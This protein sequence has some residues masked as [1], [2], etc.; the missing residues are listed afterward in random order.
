MAMVRDP[1]HLA[2]LQGLL[3]V[4]AGGL[5]PSANALVAHLTPVEKRGAIFGLTAALSGVGGFLGPL[6]GAI[7]ATSLGFR[8]TFIAAGAL[9]LALAALVIWSLASES[10]RP[11]GHPGVEESRRR[12]VAA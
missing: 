11:R 8:A 9:M 6:L 4:A 7:L 2:L 5:I 10:R 1:W 12:E 3:G